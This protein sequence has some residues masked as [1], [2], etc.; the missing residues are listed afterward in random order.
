MKTIENFKQECILRIFN[1]FKE[2]NNTSNILSSQLSD[3]GIS[4]KV[5]STTSKQLI[6][7]G[8]ITDC[9]TN[10]FVPRFKINTILPCPDFL[11]NPDLTLANKAFILMFYNF[12]DSYNKIPAREL[13]RIL[14]ANEVE[15]TTST[16]YGA[17]HR[18]KDIYTDGLFGILRDSKDITLKINHPKY[19]LLKTPS[20]Y[21]INSHIVKES[22]S[23]ENVII[24]N[25]DKLCTK[26]GETDPDK[27]DKYKNFICTKCSREEEEEKKWDN[28]GAWLLKKCKKNI[29]HRKYHNVKE[30]K[31]KNFIDI[32][33]EYLNDLYKQ[34]E[35]K[36]YYSGIEF[37]KDYRPS[38]DRLDSSKGYIKGNVVICED[39]I[40]RMK[41][42]LTLEQF[43]ER[44]LNI[45]NHMYRL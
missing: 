4:D 24:K 15:C 16:I 25:T 40:N 12:L 41:S 10:G 7:S 23:E 17:L 26:C 18:L 1:A 42:D 32:T 39:K 35:G 31:E 28:I 36:C 3:Y 27:F 9:S 8:D 21:Q 43:E 19:A 14:D 44:I 13:K 29:T 34:Q 37:N 45:Y 33:E 38:V 22:K 11:I 5:I 30:D 20:G 2:D 6:K